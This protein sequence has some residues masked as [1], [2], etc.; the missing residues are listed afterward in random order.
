MDPAR[1]ETHLSEPETVALAAY[2]VPRRHPDI[3]VDDLGV[4]AVLAEVR[5][6]VLHRRDVADHVHPWRVRGHD[7][8]RATRIRVDIGV[9]HTHHDQEVRH[10]A[11]ARE[12]FVAVYDPFLA[13]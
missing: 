5:F 10:R 13:V 9:G 7:D 11:I 2:E 8:H 1:A 6:R 12:P 3:S 4:A